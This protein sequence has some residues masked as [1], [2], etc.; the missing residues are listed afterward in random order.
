MSLSEY[1]SILINSCALIGNSSSG[2]HEATSFNIPVINIGTRQNGR[3]KPLN[4]INANYDKKDIVKKIK[5]CLNNKK[6]RSILKKVKN[7]YGDGKSASKI[8]KVLKNIN[9]SKTTQ[10]MNTY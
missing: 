5:Y 4:V 6:Y 3:L 2:I 7:P 10:K 8:I 9:L 1:K